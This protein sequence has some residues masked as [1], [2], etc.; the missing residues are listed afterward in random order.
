[1]AVSAL[2]MRR[3][4]ARQHAATRDVMVRLAPA[5]LVH[6][7]DLA[8]LDRIDAVTREI[9]AVA[10][11]IASEEMPLSSQRAE[12][13][14]V[15]PVLEAGGRT[16]SLPGGWRGEL[17]AVL[18][19]YLGQAAERVE[20]ARQRYLTDV[21]HVLEEAEANAWSADTLK[22]R[23]ADDVAGE[24]GKPGRMFGAFRS[25]VR[26][27]VR[28]AVGHAWTQTWLSAFRSLRAEASVIA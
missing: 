20:E 17:D 6:P 2:E 21:R 1:M 10:S 18:D 8:G 14:V 22:R 25:S 9:V 23:L 15:R 5:F 12:D 16:V 3:G 7:A 24:A 27:A 19:F 26:R 13:D 4:I 11:R 28:E